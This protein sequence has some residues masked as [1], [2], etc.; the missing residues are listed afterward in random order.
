MPAR[1]EIGAPV[2]WP[3]AERAQHC[4]SGEGCPGDE[5]AGVQLRDEA[6]ATGCEAAEE[7]HADDPAHLAGGVDAVP[8]ARP[9]RSAGAAS[10]TAAVSAGMVRLM[11]RPVAMNGTTST[12]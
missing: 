10:M 6:G 4:A 12:A 9:P 8:E 3:D 11:P 5:H 1:D 2:T 7:G